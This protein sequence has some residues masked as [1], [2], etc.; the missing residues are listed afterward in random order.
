MTKKPEDMRAKSAHQQIYN[1]FSLTLVGTTPLITHAW[2]E[3]ARNEMLGKQLKL[4]KGKGKEAR[5]PQHDFVNSLYEMPGG[6]YGFPVTGVKK[7]L[8]DVAHKDK[9]IAKTDVG[10]ALW[11]DFEMVSVRAALAGAV[12]DLPLVR[13]YGSEPVMREDMVK[14]GSGLSRTATLAYRGQ[15]WPWAMRITGRVNTTALPIESLSFL[16]AEAGQS[17]GI[18]EW[19]PQRDGIFGCYRQATMQETAAWD[20]FISGKGPMPSDE[21]EVA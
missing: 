15:F 11:L 8:K 21:A 14:I 16:I 4:V 2:N 17:I 3:K 7:S 5:D 9:G 20:A 18:G 12:C 13:I 19:R 10:Q 6:G 1:P